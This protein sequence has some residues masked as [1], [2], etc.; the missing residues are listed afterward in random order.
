MNEPKVILEYIGRGAAIVHVPMRDLTEADFTERAE[1]WK[2]EGITEE[3]LISSGLY[4]Y[5]VET[6]QAEKPKNKK[7]DGE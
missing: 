1:L 2:E 7:K 3:R 5:A 6:G 4:Q